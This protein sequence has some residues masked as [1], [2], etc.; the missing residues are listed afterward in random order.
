MKTIKVFILLVS[1]WLFLASTGIQGETPPG[2]GKKNSYTFS[3]AALT[4]FL[5][6][7]GEEI[8]Y[9][10][11]TSETYLSQLL[12]DMKPLFYTGTSLNVSQRNPLERPGFFTDL[13]LKF[14][15]PSY[16][17][18]IMEDRDWMNKLYHTEENN[19]ALTHFS[20][21]DNYTQGA[22]LLD[23]SAGL[24]LPIAGW[25]VLKGY[26]DFS[27]MHFSWASQNGFTQ[28]ASEGVSGGYEP[29]DD[30]IPKSTHYGPA[31]NYQQEWIILT[32]GLALLIPFPY[33]LSLTLDVHVSPWIWCVALDDHFLTEKQYSDHTS[34]GGLLFES[35]GRI[36]FAPHS[37]LELSLSLGYRS[38][39]GL[40]GPTYTRNTGKTSG[41][42]TQNG[43]GG[44]GYLVLDT[45]LSI[46]IRL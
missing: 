32:P 45:G 41:L 14:G 3:I 28:Y 4:G 37:R 44:T 6:G 8:V 42:V 1:I 5:Y 16:K 34:Q 13:S 33:G 7:Q 12:W 11:E 9:L 43:S 25:F 35:Q 24:S 29:W 36:G 10:N 23:L 21:H 18:G 27:Y 30:G 46:K 15:I 22:F 38:I 20:S 17:T 39:Q 31:I 19:D 26:A 2:A 40:R